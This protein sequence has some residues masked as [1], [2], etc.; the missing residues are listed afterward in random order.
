MEPRADFD[1]EQEIYEGQILDKIKD[2]EKR[3]IVERLMDG[4]K[5][6]D[7]YRDQKDKTKYSRLYKKK[8]ELAEELRH[9]H[10]TNTHGYLQGVLKLYLLGRL[11]N[12]PK[13]IHTMWK[14]DNAL[15]EYKQPPVG[16]I[17]DYLEDI[18]LSVGGGRVVYRNPKRQFELY[19][20]PEEQLSLFS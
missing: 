9:I 4:D 17:E 14:Y 13:K 8:Q 12:L 5:L 10:N 2:P 16:V 6:S 7:V 11:K 15:K 1:F 3:E 20:C 18:L 19:G